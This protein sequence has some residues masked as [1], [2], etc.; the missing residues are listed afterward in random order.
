MKFVKV[1]EENPYIISLLFIAFLI[2]H[3]GESPKVNSAKAIDV[4]MLSARV[5]VA[6][7]M[8][9]RKNALRSLKFILSSFRVRRLLTAISHPNP[10]NWR[11][12]RIV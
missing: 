5:D 11:K 1:L 12:G 9:P 7:S 10:Q 6:A 4:V 8:V 3:F 2:Y